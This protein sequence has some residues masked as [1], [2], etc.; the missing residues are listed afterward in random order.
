MINGSSS[1]FIRNGSKNY[2]EG[3]ND[4]EIE[5]KKEGIIEDILKK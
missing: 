5:I 4:L 2:T 3:K 1:L